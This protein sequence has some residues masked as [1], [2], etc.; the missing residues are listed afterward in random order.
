[1]LLL[2]S[3]TITPNSACGLAR[4]LKAFGDVDWAVG[5]VF[6]RGMV[7]PVGLLCSMLVLLCDGQLLLQVLLQQAFRQSFM[8][9]F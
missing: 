1:M 5:S 6:V 9:G 4:P 7:L 2:S 8:G 3:V